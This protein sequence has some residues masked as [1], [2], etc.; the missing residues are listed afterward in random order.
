MNSSSQSNAIAGI[1][2]NFLPIYDK[3]EIM[4]EKYANDEFGR[5]Y[6]GL[7]IGPTFVNMGVKEYSVAEGDTL[8]R[9][10]MNVVT[11]EYS[12]TAPKDT[13]ITQLSP[14]MELEGNV[15]RAAA[16]VIS[17]GNEEEPTSQGE[18]APETSSE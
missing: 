18:A 2:R 12:N 7:W 10:R 9:I 1:L 13:V 11:S 17:R 4:K 8:D 3:L 14:G 15:V 16:C 5:Q 6:G